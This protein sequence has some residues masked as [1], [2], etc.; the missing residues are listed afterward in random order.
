MKLIAVKR[1]SQQRPIG[2]VFEESP[3]VAR[4]LIAIK[5]AKP[6]TEPPKAQKPEPV[7]EPPKAPEPAPVVAAPVA[8]PFVPGVTLPVESQS[9]GRGRSSR[10]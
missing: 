2:T 7:P 6:Y 10:G 8:A 5:R 1:I 3:K 9:R 4:L